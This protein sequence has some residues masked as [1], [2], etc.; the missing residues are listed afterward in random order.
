[1]TAARTKGRVFI[2]HSH[3]DDEL[4]RDL[5][6]RLRKAGLEPLLDVTDISAG[7][8]RKKKLREQI[9]EADALLFLIT[10]AAL[11]SGWMMAELGMAEG[12]ERIIVPVTAGLKSVD[13]PAPFQTYQAVP[14]DEVDGAISMLAE[15]LTGAA[16][17]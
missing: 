3:Q 4:A 6:R 11:R 13:L 5:A 9:R 12:F 1:M 17:D 7:S 14:F 10:P 16:R 15:Q 8:D 2:S